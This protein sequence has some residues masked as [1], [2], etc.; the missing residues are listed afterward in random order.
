MRNAFADFDLSD[1]WKGSEYALKKYVSSLATDELIASIENELGYKLPSSYTE[2]M[3]SQNG[4]IPR[5]T[6]FPIKE[7]APWW[8]GGR[9]V[10]TGLFGIGRE[11]AYSLCGSLGSPFMIDLWEYPAI[12]VYFADCPS[13]GHDMICMDYRKCGKDGE[14]EIVHV[15]QESDYEITFLA[16]NFEAFIKGLVD[17]RELDEDEPH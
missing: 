8:L 2:L 11:K 6:A 7:N 4:G 9:A 5:K 12:G 15:D 1:F 10:L 17:E 13:A 14:P 3:E 16:P